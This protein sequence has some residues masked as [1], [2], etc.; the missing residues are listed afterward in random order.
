MLHVQWT[1]LPGKQYHRPKFGQQNMK[2]DY[3][4]GWSAEGPVILRHAG[5]NMEGFDG[6]FNWTWT[7]RR[8]VD[9]A[10]VI[11]DELV[12]GKTGL[13]VIF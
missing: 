12:A 11:T 3:F 13:A 2:T 4:V 1:C 5:V 8:D 10:R 6:F 7:Y 9:V